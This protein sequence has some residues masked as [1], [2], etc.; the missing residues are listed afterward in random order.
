MLLIPPARRNENNSI[1]SHT[2]HTTYFIQAMSVN[3]DADTAEDELWVTHAAGKLRRAS[4][5]E[6]TSSITPV[7]VEAFQANCERTITGAE[8]YDVF[9]K[10]G[11]TLGESFQWIDAI[12]RNDWEGICRMRVP[13]IQED[14]ADYVL[15][16]GLI[17]SCLQALAAFAKSD[18]LF[19]QG[20]EDIRIPFHLGKVRV[21]L[22]PEPG[23]LW[24]HGRLED[25]EG[26]GGGGDPVGVF[27]L[28]DEEGRVIAEVEGYESRRVSKAVLLAALQE[29]A[30]R[31]LYE[32]TWQERAA[33]LEAESAPAQPGSWLVLADGSGLAAALTQPMR[34]RGERCILVAAGEGYRQVGDDRFEV[35]PL[36]RSDFA[37]VLEE[38]WG[39]ETPALRGVLHLWNVD[40]RSAAEMNLEDLEEEL[41]RSSGGVLH[42]LQAWAAR[43]LMKPPRW[44]LVTRGSQAVGYGRGQVA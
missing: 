26:T 43:N 39:E 29:D 7:D 19:M 24:F 38:A 11:Y 14:L 20:G 42:T 10:A 22:R 30:S 9:W 31:W 6:T 44:F 18:S 34:L 5:E 23:P 33:P 32:V 2:V 41:Q 35:N 13:E 25:K 12:W 17:D 36:Q 3:G 28:F 16:P 21:Y 37:R 1:A 8:F 4:A 15:H 27:Y 40:A